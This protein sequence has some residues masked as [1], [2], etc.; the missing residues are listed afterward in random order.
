[1][2]KKSGKLINTNEEIENADDKGKFIFV[3]SPEKIMYAG[4]KIRG[5]PIF[6]IILFHKLFLYKYFLKFL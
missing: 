5:I 2:Y 3:V 6:K 4:P 1:M